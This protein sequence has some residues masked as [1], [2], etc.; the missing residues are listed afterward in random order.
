MEYVPADHTRP[1]RPILKGS[2]ESSGTTET[3]IDRQ[4]D[5]VVRHPFGKQVRRR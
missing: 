4:A 2:P 1:W 5:T 3:V